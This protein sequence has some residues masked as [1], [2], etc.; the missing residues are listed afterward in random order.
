M[1]MVFGL[2]CWFSRIRDMKKIVIL[3]SFLFF[4]LPV[5]ADNGF[6]INVFEDEADKQFID[7][8]INQFMQRYNIPGLSIA[9][10]KQDDILFA[11]GYGFADTSTKVPVNIAHKFRIASLSKPI[12][13]VAIMKLMEEGKLKLDDK[14]FGKDG[15]LNDRFPTKNKLLHQITIRHLLEHTAGKNWT[16]D[17]NDPMFKDYKLS[18]AN[19][20]RKTLKENPIT[21][22]PG[23]SYAYSNF[24]YC[25]LGRVIEKLSGIPYESYIRKTFFKEIGAKSFSMGNKKPSNSVTQVRYYP[26]TEESPYSFPVKRMD[27]HG[28]WLSNAIDLVKF[29]ISVDGR[30]QDILSQE[31]IKFMTIPSKHNNN[32]ALGWNVNQYNNWWHVGLLPGTASIMVRTDHG[33]SWAVLLNKK[34]DDTTFSAEL[35]K[36]TWNII[37]GIK[38]LN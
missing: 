21:S 14:V 9:I 36:L 2:C 19:L 38:A 31:S 27:A 37:G 18:Q 1:G 8:T 7:K 10:A 35:D 12:T 23:N 17:G 26:D 6:S 13:A 15:L 5:Y 29:I 3:F 25:L 28:G 16:N 33:Y 22:P 4:S 32:Y 34:S 20:I 11:K 24:G 30:G